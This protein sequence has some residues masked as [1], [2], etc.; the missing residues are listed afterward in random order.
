MSNLQKLENYCYRFDTLKT[1]VVNDLRELMEQ[2]QVLSDAYEFIEDET[3]KNL[4]PEIVREY[5][6]TIIGTLDEHRI[7]KQNI[8]VK[9]DTLILI[10]NGIKKMVKIYGLKTY[11]LDDSLEDYFLNETIKV[12]SDKEADRDLRKRVS[13]IIEELK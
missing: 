7:F 3:Y 11:G 6:W 10:N 12:L 5:M 2:Y 13:K 9:L 8:K 1:T 4:S